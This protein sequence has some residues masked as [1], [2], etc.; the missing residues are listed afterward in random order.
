MQHYSDLAPTLSSKAKRA[1]LLRLF[2]VQIPGKTLFF[3]DGAVGLFVSAV[4]FLRGLGVG[5]GI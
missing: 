4:F 3:I 2:A 5:R 1:G